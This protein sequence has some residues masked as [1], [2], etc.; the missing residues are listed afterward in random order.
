MDGFEVNELRDYTYSSGTITSFMHCRIELPN[1]DVKIKISGNYL[2]RVFNSYEPDEILIQRRF[3]IYEPLTA[4]TTSVRQPSAGEQRYSGQQLNLKINTSGLRVSDPFA[5]IKTYLCQNCL[6]QGCFERVTPVY[7]KGGEIDY[8]QPSALIFDGGNE[9][10]LFD[11]KNIRFTAQGVQSID[12]IGGLFHVQITPDQSRRRQRYSKVSDLNGRYVISLEQ[13][14]QSDIEADYVW[15]YFTLKSPVELDEDKSVYLFGEFT[16]WQLGDHNRMIY[17]PERGS[18]ELRLLLKQGLYNYRYLVAN[19][20]TGAIDITQFEGNF[21]E[22]ENSYTTLV[23][24]KPLGA[25][26]ER[27]V[28]YQKFSSVR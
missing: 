25:R 7:V 5:E 6:F 27:A 4:I 13:S 16:G 18:Y 11:I 10:R 17:N 12:Y 14:R 20:K 26:Y 2:L 28:G 24:Y 22:T 3:I 15:T 21:F 1:Q 23:Y 9:F 8:S 19:N